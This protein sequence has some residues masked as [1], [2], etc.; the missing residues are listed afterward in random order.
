MGKLSLNSS[1]NQ[2]ETSAATSSV[3]MP[4]ICKMFILAIHCGLCK[5]QIIFLNGI[6]FSLCL[7]F[8]A[9]RIGLINICV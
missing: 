1:Y 6:E 9:D 5:K 8:P 4:V 3:F 7:L 2:P